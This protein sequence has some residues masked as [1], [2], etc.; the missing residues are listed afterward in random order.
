MSNRF[1][2]VSFQCFKP[3]QVEEIN[4]EIKKNVSIKQD[5][6]STAQNVS[7]IGKFFNINCSPVIE[8]VH[9]WLYQCQE[10]NRRYFGLDI[11]WDFHLDNF[12][13]VVNFVQ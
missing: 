7:K 11:Y 10:I 13:K 12:M 8:L 1:S 5:P 2:P 6:I 9:P 4:K 3:E